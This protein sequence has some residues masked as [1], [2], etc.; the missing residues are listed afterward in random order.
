MKFPTLVNEGHPRVMAR[1][2]PVVDLPH[3][4]YESRV[5]LAPFAGFMPLVVQPDGAEGAAAA[6]FE[7][8]PATLDALRAALIPTATPGKYNG[9]IATYNLIG[10]SGSGLKPS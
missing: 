9:R 6:N 10:V 7:L 1:A 3:G 4:P 2:G 8:N 5:M